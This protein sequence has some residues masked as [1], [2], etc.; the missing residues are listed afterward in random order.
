MSL[1][2]ISRRDFTWG[3]IGDRSRVLKGLRLFGCTAG[4]CDVVGEI[5]RKSERRDFMMLEFDGLVII[6]LEL[7]FACKV[8]FLECRAP[9]I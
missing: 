9:L 8:L 7:V 5:Y 1:Y 2:S 3:R 6:Y 4:V